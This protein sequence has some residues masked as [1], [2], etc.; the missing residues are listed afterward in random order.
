MIQSTSHKSILEI[1]FTTASH[2]ESMLSFVT[3]H[4]YSSGE[5][6]AA[7]RRA[8]RPINDEKL[9]QSRNQGAGCSNSGLPSY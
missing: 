3:T 2:S 6:S 1:L 8:E 5:L 9:P 4:V 7:R